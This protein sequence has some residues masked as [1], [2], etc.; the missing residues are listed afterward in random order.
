MSANSSYSAPRSGASSPRGSSTPTPTDTSGPSPLMVGTR[1]VKQ[2]YQVLTSDTPQQIVKFYQPSSILSTGTASQ[3]SAATASVDALE[4]FP[5]N[6]GLRFEFEH[7][8]IDAQ[9]TGTSGILLVVTGQ[10]IYSVADD[11]DNNDDEQY[12]DGE[13][14]C[15]AF[16]HTI[17]LN[18]TS[19]AQGKRSYYVQNDILRFLNEQLTASSSAGNSSNSSNH[20]VMNNHVGEVAAV[21]E[22][23]TVVVSNK[24]T[25]IHEE[26][27]TAVAAASGGG[28]EE[29]KE[30]VLDEEPHED[31]NAEAVPA[32]VQEAAAAV[33]E[34]SAKDDAGDESKGPKSNSWASL[35]ARPAAPSTPSKIPTAASPPAKARAPEPVVPATVAS[36]PSVTP[37]RSSVP[38]APPASTA[39]VAKRDPELT[40]VIKNLT[41]QAKESEV[42]AMFEPFALNTDAS[43]A[44]I[45]VAGHKGIAFVD[46]SSAAPVLAIV[47]QHKQVSFQLHGKVLDVY[48]KSIERS[49]RRGGGGR[50]YAGS[51]G[52]RQHRGGRGD[53]GGRS[54]RGERG[55]R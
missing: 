42:V 36:A 27:E 52:G 40:L 9:A 24:T 8:A 16:V 17:V 29:S 1:F 19:N 38:K 35:V 47:E 4:R 34:Q 10:V 45:T 39:P 5:K 30:A 37:P 13:V 32:E 23:T 14:R 43:I 3:P 49:S 48:Q 55:G 18:A 6:I 53:R 41:A 7:G 28:V 12:E 22:E 11:E 2:Y 44:S 51:G 54:G 20:H 31:T 33:Q 46:F 21:E 26:E 50:G 15:Q 25:T